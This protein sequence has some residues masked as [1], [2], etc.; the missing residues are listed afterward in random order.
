MIL[1][2][3]VYSGKASNVV[4][5]I[6]TCVFQRC[7]RC[8]YHYVYNHYEHLVIV[9][10]STHLI[11]C[12]PLMSLSV[13]STCANVLLL[14]MHIPTLN[15]VLSY[16]SYI[17]TVLGIHCQAITLIMLI[18]VLALIRLFPCCQSPLHGVSLLLCAARALWKSLS[19]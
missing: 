15:K 12:S 14:Y 2:N 6:A 19:L 11:S 8:S 10:I 1:G 3:V 13:N 7:Y 5:P 16:L 18:R 4:A 9:S 17:L